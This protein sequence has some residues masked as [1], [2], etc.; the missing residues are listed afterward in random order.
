MNVCKT[1]A[2]R[3]HSKSKFIPITW[4][5]HVPTTAKRSD[6]G[7]RQACSGNNLYWNIWPKA[8]REGGKKR[9]GE[10]KRKK[11][12]IAVMVVS[13]TRVGRGW[14]GGK[15]GNRLEKGQ[16]NERE[17][18]QEQEIHQGRKERPVRRMVGFDCCEWYVNR[19]D[20]KIEEGRRLR[21]R[22]R[23]W[24]GPEISQVFHTWRLTWEKLVC[25]KWNENDATFL[26]VG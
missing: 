19:K 14:G 25:T 20:E 1:I 4:C 9:E 12:K 5:C 2:N 8:H 11:K 24:S 17:Q 18:E 7:N 13:E 22:I 21:R 16:K 3:T 23:G 15:G 10:E 6:D 26:I